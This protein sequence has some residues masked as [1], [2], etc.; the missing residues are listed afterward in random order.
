M[1]D[2]DAVAMSRSSRSSSL[3]ASSYST[4]TVVSLQLVRGALLRGACFLF[5]VVRS[6]STEPD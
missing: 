6:L 3:P 5:T 4:T 1:D 2:D